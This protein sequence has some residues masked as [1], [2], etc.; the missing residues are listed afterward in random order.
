MIETVSFEKSTFMKP[1]LK[2]E[3]GSPNA[4]GALGLSAAIDYLK[5]LNFEAVKEYEHNLLVYAENNLKQIEGIKIIGEAKQKTGA[6]S[7][8]IQGVHPHDIATLLDNDGIAVRAGHHCAQPIMQ[9]FKVPATARLSLAMYNTLD[10]IDFFIHSL[11][12]IKRIFPS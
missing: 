4:A 7:F 1:P 12:N 9:H 10:E 3:A 8:V 2:F 5:G 11:K 6:I